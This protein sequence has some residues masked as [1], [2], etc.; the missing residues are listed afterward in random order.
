[1]LLAALLLSA[2]TLDTETL[3]LE[4]GI[5]V[6]LL[7]LSSS[8]HISIISVVPYGLTGDEAGR[9]Q[10]SHLVEHL[11]LTSTGPISDYREVNAETMTDGMHL[12]FVRK[13]EHWKQGVELQAAWL[14]GPMVH[15][16]DLEREVPRVISEIE[17]VDRQGNSG[18][19]AIAAWAQAVG[20]GLTEVQLNAHL[21]A[22]EAEEMNAYLKRRL[23]ANGLPSIA[24]VGRFD[25]DALVEALAQQIGAI[26]LPQGKP[27]ASPSVPFEIPTTVHWDLTTPYHIVYWPIPEEI[28][29]KPALCDLAQAIGMMAWMQKPGAHQ[30][31]GGFASVDAQTSAA[32]R[33]F[34]VAIIPL[35]DTSGE[36]LTGARLHAQELS[37]RF[38]QA[39]PQIYRMAAMQAAMLGGQVLNA[40]STIA[41]SEKS[42]LDRL[43]IEGNVAVQLAIQSARASEGLA[44]RMAALRA[45]TE[46]DRDLLVKLFDTK[47]RRELFLLP[48]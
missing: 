5:R 30:R 4:N 41:Q 48:K 35:K 2:W 7:P 8:Q 1:M 12:D 38:P 28:L 34:L 13:A 37:E 16:E 23:Y 11:L 6:Q 42:G 43:L 29:A 15:A 36:T 46:E 14:A 10:V 33:P 39:I 19:M 22:L 24:I 9:A 27:L 18:K 32:G 31:P 40:E 25:R 17:N 20:F 26:P 45:V 44:K 47:Q 3:T 21:G